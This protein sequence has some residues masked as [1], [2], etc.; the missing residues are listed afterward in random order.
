MQSFYER[1]VHRAWQTREDTSTRKTRAIRVIRAILRMVYDADRCQFNL[2]ATSLV[3]TTLLSVVPLIAFSVAMLEAFGVTDVATDFLNAVLAPLGGE[4]NTIHSAIDDFLTRATPGLLGTLGFVILIFTALSMMR[5]IEGTLN[6]VWRID[7]PRSVMMRFSGY[8]TVLLFAPVF[9]VLSEQVSHISMLDH[10]IVSFINSFLLTALA[11]GLIYL[12]IPHTS[13]HV[14]AAAAGGL[15]GAVFWE[16]ANWGF[17]IFIESAT[18]LEAIYSSFAIVMLTLIWLNVLWLLL[19]VGALVC[20]YVQYPTVLNWRP[21][22]AESSYA[23][24]EYLAISVML[25]IA[26]AFA[27]GQRPPDIMTIVRNTKATPDAIRLIQDDLI[28]HRLLHRDA[29]DSKV[30]LPSRPLEQITVRD[31]LR[32]AREDGKAPEATKN[33]MVAEL[34]REIAESINNSTTLA[35]IVAR[36]AAKAD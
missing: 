31:V 13:V 9:L 1:L 36:G 6:T 24:R 35:D 21:G 20:Y 27:A 15:A 30:C 18:N 16:L 17:R 23:T 12:L 5:Q 29:A 32:V 11:F 14:K 2:R 33:P 22:R 7:S 10:P 28:S 4:N 19:M 3:F 26:E 8:I 34:L 25:K